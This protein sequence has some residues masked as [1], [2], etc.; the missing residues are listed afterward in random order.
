[1]LRTLCVLTVTA[2]SLTASA[3]AHAKKKVVES[4]KVKNKG[5]TA[6]FFGTDGVC[7]LA[8]VNVFSSETSTKVNGDK[9]EQPVTGL[10]IEYQNSCTGEAL[11]L[12]GQTFE[13]QL[14]IR[15]DLGTASLYANVPV[16]DE[17]GEST[18]INLN[19][20]WSATGPSTTFHEK[21]K[22]K[23]NGVKFK[24]VVDIEGR[25]AEAN[26]TIAGILPL[27]SGPKYKNLVFAPSVNATIDKN[28]IGQVTITKTLKN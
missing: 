22:T 2:L 19:L 16:T 26:G 15:G 28:M 24:M 8:V 17:N 6:T 18:T 5:V 12:S 3:P 9:T 23:D 20:R 4:T 11:I 13:H 14:Q 21:T 1:M 7:D 10:S 25:P 27:P